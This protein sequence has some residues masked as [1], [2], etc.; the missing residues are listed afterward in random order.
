MEKDQISL[1]INSIAVTIP[2]GSTILDAA[3]KIN[4][5]IP[6]LCNHPDLKVAGNCR[7]CV[8][9]LN[10]QKELSAACATPVKEDMEVFTNSRKVRQARKNIVELLLSEHNAD[11]TKCYRNGNC[12]LQWLASEYR[13][14]DHV[15][16]DLVKEEEKNPD[17]TSFSIIKDDSKCIRCQ[18]C[19]RTCSDLQ[20][21][22]TFSVIKKGKK[23]KI[24]TFF[25]KPL[26]EVFCID[27]GQCIMRCPT[28]ALSEKP[29]YEEV[30]DVLET[31]KH[32]VISTTPAV[33]AAIGEEL[34]FE[35]NK[36][37]DLKIVT[38]LKLLGFNAVV[39][40]GFF[41]DIF[42]VELCTEFLMRLKQAQHDINNTKLPIITSCSP[43]W[44]KYAQIKHPELSEHL[45]DCKS[46]HQIFG[47]IVK[48]YYADKKALDPKNIITVSVSPCTAAKAES[49]NP[50][51]SVHE[52]KDV[53]FTITTRELARMIRQAGIDIQQMTGSD[54][55]IL[56]H[57]HSG[58]SVLTEISGGT[59]EAIIRTLYELITGNDLMPELVKTVPLR[60]QHGIK[61]TVIKF[62]E[63]KSDWDFLEG[64]EIRFAVVNSTANAD[65]FFAKMKEQVQ[66]YHFVEVM[67]CAGGCI[68]G[69]GQPIPVSAE[70]VKARSS[71]LYSLD[72]INGIKK[73]HEN[74]ALQDIFREFLKQPGSEKAKEIVYKPK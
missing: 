4:L 60:G 52:L 6:T 43:G 16:H 1:T 63:V 74:K 11:C 18:R 28:A 9:E 49:A 42:I 37:S 57:Y 50:K 24:T 33:R 10:G 69:G 2:E 15:F 26:K 13:I 22:G 8:V 46:P 14:G 36:L 67:A 56:A 39:D 25:G 40:Y 27:C 41:T 31:E 48:S 19:V 54:Y 45:S 51:L 64:K 62:T 38:A 35:Y 30:W 17:A 66:P 68:G 44:V 61:E 72:E 29:Q 7:V 70:L 34:G 58:A 20:N 21:V 73:S 59:T 12:E 55:D 71:I 5:H 53:D 3:R 47:A 32:V 65:E 23:Q